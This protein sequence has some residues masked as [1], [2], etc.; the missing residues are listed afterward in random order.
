MP[1]PFP[2]MDPYLE[3]PDVFGNLHSDFIFAMKE[4][5]MP[6]LPEPY[7]SRSD[8]RT[9]IEVSERYVEPDVNVQ[10][11]AAHEPK[12]RR[13]GNGGV[14][15][16]DSVST[17]PVV[18]HIPHD[19]SHQ[20]FMELYAGRGE[21]RRLVASI[22][23][24]S[25]TNKSQR[26]K[27]WEA[28]LQ[29]QQ[30]MLQS[31][32]HFIEID[33]LRGGKHSTSVPLEELRRRV[34]VYDYHV[35]VHRFDRWEDYFVYPFTVRES[36]PTIDVPLLPGD[37]SVPLDLQAVFTRCFDVGPYRYEVDYAAD[38]PVPPLSSDDAQWAQERVAAHLAR[39][40]SESGQASE[41]TG[42]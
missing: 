2:G 18:I 13:P 5:L 20:T 37:G 24:L 8:R 12:Q 7:Y 15:V 41:P 17:E 23:L 31:D 25:P 3:N 6:K 19:E 30:E 16:A 4:A 36:L 32:V 21:D 33:L 14:V 40:R 38:E 9:W 27:G 28:Y 29:K 22:E 10:V 39:A 35:C 42:E 34:P 26:G 11:S 1:S